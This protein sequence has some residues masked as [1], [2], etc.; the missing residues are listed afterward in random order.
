MAMAIVEQ[1]AMPTIAIPPRRR[2]A[3]RVVPPRHP[4]RALVKISALVLVTAAAGA[5]TAASA[6]V[7]LVMLVAKLGG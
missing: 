6:C 2:G 3:L 4:G 5:L 7:A 1:P